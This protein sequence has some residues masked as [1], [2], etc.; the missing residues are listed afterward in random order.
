M[1]RK[2]YFQAFRL[3]IALYLVSALVM[4]RRILD[5]SIRSPG[6]VKC[7]AARVVRVSLGKLPLYVFPISAELDTSSSYRYRP[8]ITLRF[9]CRYLI[10]RLGFRVS[11]SI[12][13]SNFCSP[14]CYLRGPIDRKEC[15]VDHGSFSAGMNHRIIMMG[16]QSLLLF[17][18]V[19]FA[20]RYIV[21]RS[22]L[23]VFVPGMIFW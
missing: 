23:I 16:C 12:R 22:F 20:I 5:S 2:I 3:C 8:F 18:P 17:S 6:R 10:D 21:C 7:V 19:S 14:R 13:T 11:V 9:Y 1:R 4:I 15:A